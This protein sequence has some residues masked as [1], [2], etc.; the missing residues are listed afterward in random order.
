M[1]PDHA[2]LAEAFAA[3]NSLSS[4]LASSYAALERR[5]AELSEALAD[6]RSER[7]LELQAREALARRLERLMAALP[8]GV[9]VLDAADRIIDA[10]PGAVALLG[11]PLLD[12]SW[13]AVQRRAFVATAMGG[14]RVLADGR[15]LNLSLSL[16]GDADERVVL[17]SD[18]TDSRRIQTELDRKQRLAAMGEMVAGLAHQV[19][20]PLAASLLYAEQLAAPLDTARRQHLGERLS[21]RLRHL[22]RLVNDMLLF[23]RGDAQDLAPATA[24][25]L[26]EAA[27]A[28][29]APLL[30]AGLSPVLAGDALD[31]PLEVNREALIGALTNLGMNALQVAGERAGLVFEARAEGETL[32]LAALDEGPGLADAE[33]IFEPFYSTRRDGTGLGLAVVRAVAEGHGGVAFAENRARGGACVGLRLPLARR[34][35]LLPSGTQPSARQQQSATR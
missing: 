20:T 12:E 5:V 35:T 22:D 30:P 9:L 16:L 19:R 17:L 6:A 11:E 28:N 13:A 26:I 15:R 7:L 21:G 14:D 27:L 1:Q 8:G 25:E 2:Q 23:A 32:C 3:F 10:N 18:V 31:T 24:R 34:H 29:L 33:R 4:Q